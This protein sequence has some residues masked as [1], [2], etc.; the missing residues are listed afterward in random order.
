ME[1]LKQ[2]LEEK[3]KYEVNGLQ[4]SISYLERTLAG[5]KRNM[6]EGYYG[7]INSFGEIQGT[8]N[9]IDN[10]CGKISAYNEAIKLVK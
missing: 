5:L 4:Q 9:Q 3:I 10:I 1:N 8:G 7:G 6:E 2:A